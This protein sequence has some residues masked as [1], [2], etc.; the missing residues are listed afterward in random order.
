MVKEK[1]NK[2]IYRKIPFKYTEHIPKN[3]YVF[4]MR[5]MEIFG[6]NLLLSIGWD[7]MRLGRGYLKGKHKYNLDC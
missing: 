5:Y 4:I 7:I 1:N 6:K 3:Q 2:N